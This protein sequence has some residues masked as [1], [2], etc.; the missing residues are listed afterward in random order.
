M[1][2]RPQAADREQLGHLPP[3]TLKR[4]AAVVFPGHTEYYEPKTYDLLKR[5]R[6]QGGKL[7]FLQ[8]N[9]FYRQVRVDSSHNAVVMTDYDA[10]EGRSDFALAGVGYDGC[11]FPRSRAARYVAAGGRD[12]TRVRWLFR[13]TGIR[14]G[15]PFGFAASESD[16]IDPAL[17]PHDHVVAA[18]AIIA[19]KHGVV[20]AALVWLRAS[21]G[22][23]FATGNYDFLRMRRSLSWTLLD[24]VWRR[25][26][27]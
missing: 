17:T 25:L 1:A 27:G 11:C 10:R 13:D 5:Y 24:N 15:E 3:E 23:V 2:L 19:G 9:P 26:V 14:P 6:D 8:A 18:E 7:V 21:R 22:E 16:R 20:N 12:F 4:Y